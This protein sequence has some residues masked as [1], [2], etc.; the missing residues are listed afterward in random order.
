MSIV[1][2]HLKNRLAAGQLCASFNVL[3]WRSV[4]IAK[5][6]EHLG[7]HWLFIDYEHNSMDVDAIAQMCI[8][9]LGT[10]ITPIIRVPSHLSHHCTR[11]LDNGAM[12]VI[13]PHISTVEEA[14]ELVNNTRFPPIGH[15]S[16]TS[17]GAQLGYANLPRPEQVKILN[18]N[19]FVVAMIESPEGIENADAIAAIDGIDALLIGANDLAM[20]YGIP[21][22]L[23]H[24]VIDK[25][26]DTMCNACK[27]HGK[28]AGMGGVYDHALM[29]RFIGKGVRFLQAAGEMNLMEI[30][31]KERMGF[32][33]SI[34]VPKLS[35]P[36]A[37]R[38]NTTKRKTK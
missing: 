20:E 26:F 25:A 10:P 9:A 17:P 33:N 5:I 6:A 12:G 16:V 8:A 27:K 19:T 36:A 13:V 29:Q 7:F 18:Q 32:I 2:N 28:H 31:A 4:N 21:G 30:G 22:Q 35:R 14:R 24:K 37:K 38:K 1:P 3:H 23:N 34:K 15:R 11:L